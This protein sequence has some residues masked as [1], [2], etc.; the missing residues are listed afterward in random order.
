[1]PIRTKRWNDP[2]GDDDGFRLLICRYR[3]RA[4][5][6]EHEPSPFLHMSMG[7]I[8]K[9]QVASLF[10]YGI[11]V[12][13]RLLQA[14]APLSTEQFTRTILP[15]FGSVHLTLVHMLGAD[16]L[17]FARWQGH[18]PKTMLGPNDLPTLDIIRERWAKLI[19][20]RRYNLASL[21]ET[22]LA[23]IVRWT[24]MRGQAFELP[25]WQ[26]MLH[27]VNHATHHRSELAAMLS[28]L[29]H[30]PASTDLLQYYL[31]QA[32]QQWKPTGR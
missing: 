5:K 7:T 11:W 6:K 15:G 1:M 16:L 12:N 29:G 22:E 26:V 28:T 14:A 18:S 24:N 21:N 2:I 32:G 13:E 31:E 19:D 27:C 3:P 8:M 25:R 17:W 30:E 20:E 10:E 23:A 9:E 4:L